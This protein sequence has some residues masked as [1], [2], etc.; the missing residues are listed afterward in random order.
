MPHDQQKTLV[1]SSFILLSKKTKQNIVWAFFDGRLSLTQNMIIC[2][3]AVTSDT[4]LL[5]F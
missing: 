1:F 4:F 3:D 5:Q 2:F